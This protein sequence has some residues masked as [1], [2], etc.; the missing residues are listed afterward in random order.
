MM[1]AVVKNGVPEQIGRIFADATGTQHS[2]QVLSLWTAEE[3]A[4]I[5]VYPVTDGPVPDGHVV[6][7]SALEWGGGKVTRVF[8]SEPAPA[9]PVPETVSRFQARAA[10]WK[11]SSPALN[12][13][14]EAIG[15][16]QPEIDDLFRAA[17][18]IEA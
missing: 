3:L 10:L 5:D 9:P 17:A 4:A 1:H 15:L 16:T 2:R 11:R 14:A 12:G 8:T 18:E 7:G 6:T 13:L